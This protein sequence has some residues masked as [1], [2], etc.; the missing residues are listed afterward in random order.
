MTYAEMFDA[1]GLMAAADAL[2]EAEA[3]A[4]PAPAGGATIIHFVP[5][6]DREPDPPTPAAPALAVVPTE[7]ERAAYARGVK[8]G[9]RT[10]RGLHAATLRDS[11]AWPL[12]GD[13][14]RRAYHRGVCD[15]ITGDAPPPAFAP[16]PFD[17]H[18]HCTRIGQLGGMRTL[19]RHGRAHFV[20]IGRAGYRATVKA[21]RVAYVNGLLKAKR[22]DGPRRPD[23]A[24]DLAA[25]RG[26][27]DLDRAA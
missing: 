2:D 25:G 26:L 22:W 21:H 16:R 27:A 13:P 23:L 8:Q 19:E 24:T 1:D 12:L 14:I 4:A 6:G 15:G 3:G 18:T 11:A 5:A 10:N 9:R 17:R 20:A 7:A